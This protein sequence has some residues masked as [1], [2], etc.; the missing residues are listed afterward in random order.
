M[1][2]NSASYAGDEGIKTLVQIT[3]HS[4]TL[5][6]VTLSSSSSSSK[7]SLVSCC[8]Q[9][10]LKSVTSKEFEIVFEQGKETIITSFQ[11]ETL[12]LVTTLVRDA[13]NGIFHEKH[14]KIVIRLSKNG[15]LGF[16]SGYQGIAVAQL[17]LHTLLADYTPQR[18]TLSL[19]DCNG[20]KGGSVVVTLNPKFI[21]EVS[22]MGSNF[23]SP[24]AF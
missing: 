16:G 18:V 9:R 3:I 12:S 22:G 24:I 11:S 5:Q 20:C 2:R 7:K 1:S 4:L 17:P 23:L 8:F 19:V 13:K 6:D 15:L 21:S 14:S 10:G